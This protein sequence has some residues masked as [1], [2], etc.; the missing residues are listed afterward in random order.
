MDQMLWVGNRLVPLASLF[1]TGE[2]FVPSHSVVQGIL[3]DNLRVRSNDHRLPQ[4]LQ[5]QAWPNQQKPGSGNCTCC[6]AQRL[7]R[8]TYCFNALRPDETMIPQPREAAKRARA[9]CWSTPS[10]PSE[11]TC[12][13]A[14]SDANL[15]PFAIHNHQQSPGKS[16]QTVCNQR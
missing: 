4:I 5:G 14:S 2:P 15:S 9:K 3:L 8:W 1:H 6:V 13:C 11:L 16:F 12:C 7:N 10:L